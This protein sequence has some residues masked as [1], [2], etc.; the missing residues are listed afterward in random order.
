[1]VRHGAIS[2]REK[3][4]S[5]IDRREEVVMLALLCLRVAVPVTTGRDVAAGQVE[6]MAHGRARDRG[7]GRLTC[8]SMCY[9]GPAQGSNEGTLGKI[10]IINLAPKI[11]HYFL[12]PKLAG[13]L[14]E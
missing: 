14:T 12:R 1:M 9:S 8:Y 7:R 13:I 3:G 6:R 2:I 11:T 10:N 4:V 5:E